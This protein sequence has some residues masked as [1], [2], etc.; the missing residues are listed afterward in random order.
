MDETRSARLDAIEAWVTGARARVADM[1]T[2]FGV[3]GA[4]S[5]K[6]LRKRVHALQREA[7][8][9]LR[10]LDAI[11]QERPRKKPGAHA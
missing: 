1:T 8:A 4:A 5:R 7:K 11:A 6:H 2:E 9:Q 3:E 10:A